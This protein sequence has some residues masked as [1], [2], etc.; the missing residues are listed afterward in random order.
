MG[1]ARAVRAA[2][3]GNDQFRWGLKPLYTLIFADLCTPAMGFNEE[4][5]KGGSGGVVGAGVPGA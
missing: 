5:T 3:R 4:D 1:A 2:H